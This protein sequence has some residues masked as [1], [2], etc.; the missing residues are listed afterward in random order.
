MKR[1]G[2][3]LFVI[4]LCGSSLPLMAVVVCDLPDSELNPLSRNIETAIPQLAGSNQDIR[5]AIDPG[6]GSLAVSYSVTVHPLDDRNPRLT[7]AANG[8]AWVVWWRD[9]AIDKVLYRKRSFSDGSWSSERTLSLAGESSRNPVAV[10][11]G[12][13][14]WVVYEYTSGGFKHIAVNITIDE[15]DP[16][17]CRTPVADTDFTGDIQALVHAESGHLWVTWVDGPTYV[18]YS[19]YNYASHTW[20]APAFESYATDSVNAARGRIRA[21]VLAN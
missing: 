3:L 20:S 5:Y 10:H 15:P 19:V 4:A 9:D 1:L 13:N 12:A 2:A 6:I 14:T 8:D 17:G 7:I 18:G 16:I 11:D 21:A